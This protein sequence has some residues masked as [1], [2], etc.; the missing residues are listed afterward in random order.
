MEELPTIQ[1]TQRLTRTKKTKDW[2]KRNLLYLE[3]ILMNDDLSGSKINMYR[4]D[5]LYH[6]GKLSTKEVAKIVNPYNLKDFTI[7]ADFKNFPIGDSR[8]QTLLGEEIKRLFD[9][10]FFITNRDAVSEIEENKKGM[11]IN[12]IQE[13]IKAETGSDQK[14]FEEKMGKF[15]QYISYDWQDIREKSANELLHHFVLYLDLKSIW[16]KCWLDLILYGEW[17]IDTTCISGKPYQERVDP[18]TMWWNKNSE[19]PFIDDAS[20]TIRERYIPLGKVIDFYYEYLSDSDIQELE[21]KKLQ[22]NN[23]QFSASQQWTKDKDGMIMP[24]SILEIDEDSGSNRHN[25]QGYYDNNGNVRVVEARWMSLK[26]VAKV[27]DIEGE[28]FW[29]GEEYIKQDGETI[30]WFWINEPW[31]CTRIAEDIYI[32]DQPRDV[33][34]RKLDNKSACSLGYSGTY[35]ER[36]VYDILKEYQIKYSAYMYRTEQAVIKALGKIG[37]LDLAMIPDEWDL[38][39]WMY[40][41]TTMGWAV[42]DSF[43]EGKKGAAMGKLAGGSNIQ[44]NTI[45]LE[46]G[47]FI[48]QNIQM[49]MQLEQQMDSVIGIN[50]QRR[51]Q[52]SQDAGLGTTQEAKQASATITES[53]FTLHDNAKLRSLEKLLEVSKYALRNKVESIQYITS[54]MTSKIFE[55][56][57]NLINEAEYGGRI[58]NASQDS[59]ALQTLQRAA[60]IGVQSGEVDLIQLMTIFSNSSTADIKRKI[61]KSVMEKR[62]AQSEQFKAEMEEK[63]KDKETQIELIRMVNEDK[64]LDRELARYKI[65]A[66]NQT[67]LAIAELTALGMAQ[68]E[69]VDIIGQADLSL[70]QNEFMQNVFDKSQDRDH[71]SREHNDK[72]AL[73]KQKIAQ[74]DRDL[75][76]KKEIADKKAKT[77]EMKAKNDLKIARTNKN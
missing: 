46:Q 69:P 50:P 30:E 72:I 19:F 10:K 34:Y 75:K 12:F 35:M 47:Q 29:V 52:I 24:G 74:K 22:L 36:N 61:E 76:L 66:D 17:I 77:E 42:T 49:L 26:K 55:I 37:V 67:K 23:R 5:N 4:N 21:E 62:Q 32:K 70:K 40:Y 14:A 13:Q 43:K 7:P 44:K 8:V 11:F 18:K 28:E 48:Q 73:E 64:D 38:D 63:Q 6:R 65:D 45:D 20:E 1:P 33:A 16:S 60:E 3:N 31:E 68:D 15:Q 71:K 54:N 9:W 53:Y 51:G 59:Q 57:G 41:A 25:F 39:M 2:A 27:T 56:D 58:G